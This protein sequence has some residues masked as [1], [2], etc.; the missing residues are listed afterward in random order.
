MSADHA[1]TA[2]WL[3][4]E[5]SGSTHRYE[6]GLAADAAE[7]VRCLFCA[8][9][10]MVAMAVLSLLEAHGVELA[11]AHVAPS[12]RLVDGG[13]GAHASVGGGW[14]VADLLW[15]R[16]PLIGPTIWE[17][18]RLPLGSLEDELE[19]QLA[20]AAARPV[21]G[22]RTGYS[23]VLA[24]YLLGRL[25]SALAGRSWVGRL[26]ASLRELVG[27]S[28]WL[29]PDRELLDL[30]PDAQATLLA[31]HRGTDVPMVHALTRRARALAS[32]HVGA[33][34]SFA[35]I[36]SWFHAFGAHLLT[37]AGRTPVFPSVAYLARAVR[38][39]GQQD[40]RYAASFQVQA[41]GRPGGFG[42]GPV[43]VV[44][45]GGALSVWLDPSGGRVVAVLGSTFLED[46]WTRR[47]WTAGQLADAWTWAA[48]LGG[49]PSLPTPPDRAS[50]AWEG[51]AR[52]E[53][54]RVAS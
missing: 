6:H 18:L 5:P 2:L 21:E 8:S 30:S 4:A 49:R 1:P 15:H 42:I 32:P 14:P 37:G 29:R 47:R 54:D 51:S 53:V 25:A 48:S 50:I 27:P 45:A 22:A 44:A 39:G 46:P 41:P 28:L 31:R 40:Q 9:K 52:P 13:V 17:A 36:V 19:Q 3:A 20:G 16:S 10:P 34:G 11:S 24:W 35:A 23:D 33:Y 26:Q 7:R 12:G 38:G 43:G